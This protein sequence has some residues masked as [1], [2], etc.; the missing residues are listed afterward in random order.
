MILYKLLVL[1]IGCWCCCAC[2]TSKKED[3]KLSFNDMGYDST[4]L[5]VYSVKQTDS[6]NIILN[7]DTL[8]LFCSDVI[9]SI[10]DG[11]R[12]S[13]WQFLTA[14]SD[15]KYKVKEDS[16][17]NSFS[18]I[19]SC[20]SELFIHPARDC[21]R[22]LQ[23]CPYPYFKNKEIG[24]TWNWS[25]DVGSIWAIDSLYPIK[26]VTTFKI[27]YKLKDTATLKTK[28]GDLFCYHIVAIST[29]QFGTA[30]AS[31]FLNNTY[32]LVYFILKTTN[33]LSFEFELLSKVQ[34]IDGIKCNKYF[35]WQYNYW[36]N[37]KK[38]NGIIGTTFAATLL[39]P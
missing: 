5:F 34:G 21:Y 16:H 22:I 29:S 8:G 18:G 33:K 24:G 38:A 14:D 35:L 11:Q 3:V 27:E 31:Y 2:N 36:K 17:H 12:Y 30:N 23:F 13:Q 26:T 39:N 25:F 37:N 4:G 32:G 6:N 15:Q 1:F 10:Q 20:D 19:E 28:F 7:I 9:M